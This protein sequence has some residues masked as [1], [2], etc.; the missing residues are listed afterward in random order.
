ME[1]ESVAHYAEHFGHDH[2]VKLS[3]GLQLLMAEHAPILQEAAGLLA[4]LADAKADERADMQSVNALLDRYRQFA[5]LLERH[6]EKEER[7]LFGLLKSLLGTPHGPIEIMELE[8]EEIRKHMQ[9]FAQ[10]GRELS[11]ASLHDGLSGMCDAL[12]Q[13]DEVMRQHF[14]KEEHAIFP[15]AEQL[16]SE[17][18]K[19]RIARELACKQ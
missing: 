1:H 19:E 10:I 6:S 15:M 5:E 17:E 2:T 8:H 16:L 18:Q 9:T 7:V 3:R 11:A 14:Y 12:R 4:A 13:A